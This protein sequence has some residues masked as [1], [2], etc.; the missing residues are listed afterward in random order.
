ME[1]DQ[2]RVG[3]SVQ[4][5]PTISI[6]L[7]IYIYYYYYILSMQKLSCVNVL[8]CLRNSVEDVHESHEQDQQKEYC[9]IE[10]MMLFDHSCNL[11]VY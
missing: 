3:I 1:A 8:G 4:E 11:L 6:Y 10:T 5:K 7:S 9:N 2:P